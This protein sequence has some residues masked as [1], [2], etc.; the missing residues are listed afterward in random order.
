[1]SIFSSSIGQKPRKTAFNLSH[2]WKGTGQFCNLI[3]CL[4]EEVLPSDKWKFSVESF[5]RF[6]PMVTPI[7]QR[8]NTY[9]HFFFVPNRIIFPDWESFISPQG[10]TDEERPIMPSFTF[11]G[12]NAEIPPST[13]QNYLIYFQTGSLSDYL[14]V[15]VQHILEGNEGALLA[16]SGLKFSLLPFLAYQRIFLEYYADESQNDIRDELKYLELV[17]RNGETKL[18]DFRTGDEL[19]RFFISVFGIR[20]RAWE[21]DYF[22]SSL[23]NTQRGAEVSIGAYG[24]ASL[25]GAKVTLD[26]QDVYI[27]RAERVGTGSYTDDSVISL[28]GG[29]NKSLYASNITATYDEA[30]QQVETSTQVGSQIR[31]LGRSSGGEGTITDSSDIPINPVTINELRRAVKL[32]EFLERSM[33]GGYRLIEQIRAHFGVISSDARLQRPQFL[34]GD[35]QKVMVSEITASS[36]TDQTYLGQY[37]GHGTEVGN[38]KRRT[39]FSEEHGFI[40]CFFSC[41]PRTSYCQGLDRQF[42][43][44]DWLDF[45][46]PEFAHLGE[47]EVK[48]KELYIGATGARNEETFGYQSRYAEYKTIPSQVHG[49]FKTDLDIWSMVRKFNTTPELSYEFIHPS[50]NDESIVR[51]FTVQS[52]TADYLFI[53]L[54]HK[55]TCSRP[56]PKFGVPML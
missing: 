56:L 50:M 52:E 26:S 42:S 30:S 36:T 28:E 55:I 47:Q 31:L 12:F 10:I 45:A 35:I 51:P 40:F 41:M 9:Q 49:S 37:S 23:P 5:T 29:P 34:G 22:T 7:M 25:D 8:I 4:C 3:P 15:N 19:T 11:D 18:S 1:M 2:E 17:A 27:G 14:G 21:K 44:F 33:R 38:T 20:Q 39:F 32:Q 54:Y 48:E 6:A 16:E 24:T 13:W 53:N 46:W 43:R